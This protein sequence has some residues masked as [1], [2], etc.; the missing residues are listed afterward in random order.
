MTL[1][2]RQCG[3]VC[4]IRPGIPI[5]ANRKEDEETRA[6]AAV[7][8]AAAAKAHE[9][10][11]T[12]PNS[13]AHLTHE[14]IA[15]MTRLLPRNNLRLVVTPTAPVAEWFRLAWLRVVVARA[16]RDLADSRWSLAYELDRQDGGER[17]RDAEAPRHDAQRELDLAIED[18]LRT[19]TVRKVDAARKQDI[20]GGKAWAEKYR[21]H[22]QAMVDEDLARYP[23][24]P[25][26]KRASAGD[27]E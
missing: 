22:W 18:A 12:E 23:A 7:A 9:L 3:N 27:A 26:A 8:Q 6:M 11:Q 1:P 21:P 19:P 4:A 2:V 10:A 13:E 15:L 24:R 16:A 25:R 17:R 14:R 5:G 20:I